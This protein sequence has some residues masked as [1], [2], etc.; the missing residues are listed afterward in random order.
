MGWNIESVLE[1]FFTLHNLVGWRFM[2]VDA[3]GDSGDFGKCLLLNM[4]Y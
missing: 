2:E 4:S 1:G 3:A